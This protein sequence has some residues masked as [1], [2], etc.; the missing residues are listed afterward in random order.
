MITGLY[1]IGWSSNLN[2]LA[3][4]LANM[5]PP[6]IWKL[7]LVSFMFTSTFQYLTLRKKKH[8]LFIVQY[9]NVKQSLGWSKLL[10]HMVVGCGYS[11]SS[12]CLMESFQVVIATRH[13]QQVGMAS[14]LQTHFLLVHP[15]HH[16]RFHIA[17]SHLIHGT[18]N[19]TTT[20]LPVVDL[21]ISIVCCWQTAAY[22]RTV[23]SRDN[24]PSLM[25]V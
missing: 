7:V 18:L 1:L 17:H 5:M 22:I 2:V 4:E 15:L 24:W 21:S 3:A 16:Q 19:T 13:F 8:Q 23:Q 6:C 12:P 20:S 9:N 14:H 11:G 25:L 10:E